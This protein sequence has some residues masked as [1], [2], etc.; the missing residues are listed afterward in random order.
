MPNKFEEEIIIKAYNFSG[1]CHGLV[2]ILRRLDVPTQTGKTLQW[3]EDNLEEYLM[4]TTF[5]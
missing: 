3:I 4:K 5:S 2:G 1:T